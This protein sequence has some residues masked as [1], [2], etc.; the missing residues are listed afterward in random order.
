MLDIYMCILHR[1]D[2]SRTRQHSLNVETAYYVRNSIQMT[3]D[4]FFLF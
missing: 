4:R 3:I 1:I 2:M